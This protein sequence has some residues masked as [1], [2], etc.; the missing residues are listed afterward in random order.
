MNLVLLQDNTGL[1]SVAVAI[2]G[3]SATS[4]S[5]GS[6]CFSPEMDCSLL[7]RCEPVQLPIHEANPGNH[8]LLLFTGI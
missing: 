8:F 3:L 1:D 4:Q 2:R 6:T 5:L 7:S